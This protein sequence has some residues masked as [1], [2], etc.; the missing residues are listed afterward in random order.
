MAMAKAT[1]QFTRLLNANIVAATAFMH[2]PPQFLSP[3]IR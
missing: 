3:F 2:N 1:G